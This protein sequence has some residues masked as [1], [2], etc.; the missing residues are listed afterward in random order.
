MWHA[1]SDSD[2]G[3][4]QAFDD[5]EGVTARGTLVTTFDASDS[6][7]AGAEE[8]GGRGLGAWKL[9]IENGPFHFEEEGVTARGTLG[10]AT[11]NGTCIRAS[12]FPR[13][14]V[15]TFTFHACSRLLHL[16][17][18]LHYWTCS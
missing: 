13:R 14:S 2:G 3:G 11:G 5:V 12:A 15:F 16:C 8:S 10:T 9:R 17:L 6:F 1:T 18:I 4:L 7:P